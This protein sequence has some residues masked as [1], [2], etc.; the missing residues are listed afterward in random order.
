MNILSNIKISGKLYAL[1]L[2]A[3]VGMIGIAGMGQY[4][5][6]RVFDSA[7]YASVNTVP[8]FNALNDVRVDF[9][10]MRIAT[11]YHVLSTNDARM[12]ALDR[13]IQDQ[14][15]AIAKLL[16]HYQDKLISDAE[17]KRHLDE[18]SALIK[19][20]YRGQDLTLLLSRQKKDAEAQANS[21]N[22]APL[23]IK[24]DEALQRHLDFNTKLATEG[25][26]NALAT[27]NHGFWMTILIT[28]LMILLLGIFGW[29]IANREL[30]GPIGSVVDNLKL[31]AG[32][33]LEVM[34]AGTK[35]RDEVGDIARAAQVFKEFVQK[36]DTQGWIK[37][38]GAEIVAALQHAENFTD[39][40]QTAISRIAPVIGAG[41]GAIY[42]VDSERRFTLLGSYGYRERKHL[43]N[44]FMIGEGLVGQAAM[45]KKPITLSAPKDY[46]Q[47][48]SGLGEGPPACVAV[49]PII[50][51]DRVL[52]V[53]EVAS[54]QQ[55]S[56]REIA[57]L[58][59]LIPALAT[60]MEIMD[61][62]QRTKD[63]LASTQEQAERMEKQA[64]Q[65]E[66]QTVEMEA[67]QA[68]LLETENWF[69]SI[70]ETAPEGMLVVGESGNIVLSNPRAEALFGY[71]A[72]ELL[73]M[74]VDRLVP[75]GTQPGHPALRA[76]FMADDKRHTMVA[77]V[78][79]LRKGGAEFPIVLS[80]SRLPARG[81]RGRCVSVAVRA[82][83][84][85]LDG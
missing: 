59:T 37:T 40:A 2:L 11:L 10:K 80:L 53:L 19:D 64:A 28:T 60:S 22:I 36:L 48:N 70:I 44:S 38:H 9:Q 13:E 20:F 47:I 69:R 71:G 25:S 56:E 85:R 50:H 51:Q 79:G 45:E 17:D 42:V 52:A 27:Q 18:V 49:L 26:E 75:T 67:Q 55:F 29:V 1:I 16:N 46:I 5:M 15:E 23:A 83:Q 33:S 12:V 68:E 21:E 54:F 78:N 43:N 32:G 63:L 6:G 31:L 30:A 81:D 84:P 41:H 76:K 3:I 74:S 82:I 14:R 62:N 72:G 35:R 66:E 34:I 58:D 73:S 65:L 8:S 4:Q 57:L 61:R 24:V 39:L 77:N 7:N